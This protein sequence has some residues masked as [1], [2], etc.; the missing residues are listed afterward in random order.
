VLPE[1]GAGKILGAMAV[2]FLLSCVAGGAAAATGHLEFSDVRVQ[3]AVQCLV[4]I[5]VYV[6]GFL[7]MDGKFV[8]DA[9]ALLRPRVI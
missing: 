3:L 9:V 5:F 2:P 7:M 8:R 4:G 6:L 1:L